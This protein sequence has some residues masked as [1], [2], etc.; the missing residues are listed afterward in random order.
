MDVL[1]YEETRD[2]LAANPDIHH[3]YGLDRRWKKQ[4]KRYQLK[5]QWQLIQTLRQQRYDMVLNPPTSGRARLSAT[6][7]RRDADW[8]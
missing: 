3:I 6:D 8:F 2:M 5:M 7:R 1:L 4:G